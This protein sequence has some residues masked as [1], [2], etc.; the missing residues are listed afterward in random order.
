MGLVLD[1]SI[2]PL[3]GAEYNPRHIDGEDLEALR[4]SV[5]ELGIVKPII[6]N[7]ETIVAGHQRTRALRAVGIEEAPVYFID[8]ELT[9]YDEVIFNQLHNGTDSDEMDAECFVEGLESVTGWHQ[10]DPECVRGNHR[11]P[12]AIFRTQMQKLI[13]KY[14]PWG[15]CV[16]T[17]DGEVIHCG[18]YALA[19]ALVGEPVLVFVI[20]ESDREKFIERL[21]RSYGVYSYDHVEKKDYIQSLA[22]MPRLRKGKGGVNSMKKSVLYETQ[23]I[24]WLRDNPDAKVLDFGCGH[25]DYVKMLRDEYDI[26]GFDPFHRKRSQLNISAINRMADGIIEAGCQ[27][28]AVVCDSVINSVNCVESRDALFATISAFCR[29]GGNVFMAGRARKHRENVKTFTKAATKSKTPVDIAFLD[30]HGFTGTYRRGSWF[31]QLFIDKADVIKFADVAGMDVVGG[32]FPASAGEWQ[33]VLKVR[34][35][36]PCK[37]MLLDAVRWEFNLPVSGDARLGRHDVAEALSLVL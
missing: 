4:E 17:Q 20:E 34:D 30:E 32:S 31:F 11:A 33:G 7:G 14:G 36:R 29:P 5:T 37:E 8:E 15:G 13:L 28:D 16:A 2:T 24:P 35:E 6:A 26:R 18:Q 19:C 1:A 10:A 3:K 23:V 9:V 12:G 25:G 22:Q 21:G 27:F